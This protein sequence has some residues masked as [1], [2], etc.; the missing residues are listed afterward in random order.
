[1]LEAIT[2]V[3][4]WECTSNVPAT[5]QSNAGEGRASD[6]VSRVGRGVTRRPLAMVARRSIMN[7]IIILYSFI[8]IQVLMTLQFT[9]DTLKDNSY[10]DDLP[11]SARGIPS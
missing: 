5:N 9:D 6:A 10:I 3:P 2:Q 11:V 4:L 7:Y 8:P 1:M